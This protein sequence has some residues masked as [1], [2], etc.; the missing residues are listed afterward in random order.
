MIKN[1]VDSSNIHLNLPNLSFHSMNVISEYIILYGGLSLK[2]EI[3]GN[4]YSITQK[5]N[6]LRKIP[7]SKKQSK[8][9]N[10]N[11]FPNSKISPFS[12]L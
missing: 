10:K 7:Y 9:F 4:F 2:N 1:I 11:R 3:N 5:G 8:N 12:K 6:D